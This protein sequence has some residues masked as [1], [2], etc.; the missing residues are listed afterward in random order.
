MGIARI[1]LVPRSRPAS[2]L[3][4]VDVINDFDFPG[5]EAL[6]KAGEAASLPLA[7]LAARA[8]K[9]RVPVIYVN[10]NFGRWRS[11]WRSVV[12]QCVSEDAPGHRV[13]RRLRPTADDYFVLKP[14]HS[15][16]FSTPLDILLRY[17]GVDTVV[18]TGFAA[19]I[20]IL[21]TANDAYMRDYRVVVPR[22]C[23]ASNTRAKTEFALGSVREVLKGSTP[24]SASVR[25]GSGSR[26]AAGGGRSP[27]AAG[28]V[29][30]AAS[31]SRR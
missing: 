22:D 5:S 6:V 12:A 18:L 7:R 11:D 26:K 2:A 30:G 16:F 15:G 29:V 27:R 14:K 25:F 31:R 24:R 28:R 19:D 23:V 8:R 9:A 10:D 17:L 20:C 1:C 13:A 21:L 3:L 4:L